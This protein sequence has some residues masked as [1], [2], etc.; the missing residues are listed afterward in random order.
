MRTSVPF[1][2]LDSDGNAVESDLLEITSE[3]VLVDSV[4]VEQYLY[5]EREIDMNMLGLT[6]GEDGDRL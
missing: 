3:S 1:R 2:L 5:S 4:V 6:T